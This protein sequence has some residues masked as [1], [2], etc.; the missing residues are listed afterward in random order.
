MMFSL[1]LSLCPSGGPSDLR[2]PPAHQAVTK[3]RAP[4]GIN[5]VFECTAVATTRI[6]RTEA[7]RRTATARSKRDAK[8]LAAALALDHL[9]ETHDGTRHVAEGEETGDRR[10]AKRAAPAPHRLRSVR[11]AAIDYSR[12]L[13]KRFKSG[14][15]VGESSGVELLVPQR[16]RWGLGYGSAEAWEQQDRLVA[17]LP[18]Q[19]AFLGI[20]KKYA[21]RSAAAANGAAPLFVPVAVGGRP[22]QQQQ[23]P[24]PYPQQQ[25]QQHPYPQQ[26]QHYQPE[27]HVYGARQQQHGG[28]G[29]GFHGGGNRAY[30]APYG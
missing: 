24:H 1:P 20:D 8:Q 11:D 19:A 9:L 6:Q 7:A 27:G 10:R 12:P 15:S 22:V 3:R 25:Q 5:H 14:G 18:E 13:T 23:Q 2:A 21:A 17:P 26:Q 29:G 16:Q 30:D 28:Y 4:P